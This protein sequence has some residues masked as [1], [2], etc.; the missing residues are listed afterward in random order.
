MTKRSGLRADGGTKSGE[1]AESSSPTA[2]A[3]GGGQPLAGA[4]ETLRLSLDA[5][6]NLDYLTK[7]NFLLC[8]TSS[9]GQIIVVSNLA[10]RFVKKEE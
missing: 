1:G 10:F 6:D 9:L 4:A 8:V 2:P 5:W 7:Q 3:S